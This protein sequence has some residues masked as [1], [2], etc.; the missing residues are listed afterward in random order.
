MCIFSGSVNFV[1]ST[2]IFA[3]IENLRQAIIYDMHLPNP[4]DLAMVLPV[5][6]NQ[7]TGENAMEFVDLSGYPYLFTDL[8]SCFQQKIARATAY[9]IDTPLTVQQ[10][11][12]FEASYVP[13]GNDFGRLDKRFRL[14][15]DLLN[16]LP[17][18]RDLRL[19]GF[20]IKSWGTQ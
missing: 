8:E 12:V 20:P 6:I 17:T 14:N 9:S 4:S 2:R 1:R 15:R 19:C 11:G 18:V 7:K 16:Q 10:V 3:R 13:S 5:P